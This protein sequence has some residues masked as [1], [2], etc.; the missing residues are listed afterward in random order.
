[1]EQLV[2]ITMT[3][4]GVR[5]INANALTTIIITMNT[6]NQTLRAWF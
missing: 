5:G 1:M 3:R 4:S 6:R 2:Y